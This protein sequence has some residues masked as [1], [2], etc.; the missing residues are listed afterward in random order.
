MLVDYGQRLDQIGIKLVRTIKFEAKLIYLVFLICLIQ[1]EQSK[2]I[3]LQSILKSVSKGNKYKAEIKSDKTLNYYFL[4]IKNMEQDSSVII[5][6]L[7]CK[8]GYHEPIF[9]LD[10]KEQKGILEISVDNDFGENVRVLYFDTNT[11]LF[12]KKNQN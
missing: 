6:T 1:C 8:K 3:E 12:I 5:D 4:I 11:R 2:K 10:W 9:G 7:I